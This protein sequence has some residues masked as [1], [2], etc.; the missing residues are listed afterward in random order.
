[1]WNFWFANVFHVNKV[2]EFS[3][4]CRYLFIWGIF[5]FGSWLQ[6]V[7]I[8]C[9]FGF[10][11]QQAGN[12]AWILALSFFSVR[13]V[14]AACVC[15]LELLGLDSLRLRVDLKVANIIFSYRTRNKESQHNQIRESLGKDVFCFKIEYSV[16]IERRSR[17]G[18]KDGAKLLSNAVKASCPLKS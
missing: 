13:S 1:M 17:D 5:V 10:R 8:N 4:P 6:N 12:E 18:W 15:F 11:I 2:C 3:K 9:C 14:G 7:C 16:F